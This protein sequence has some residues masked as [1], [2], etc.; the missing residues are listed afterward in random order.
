MQ[1]LCFPAVS[2]PRDAPLLA[3]PLLWK[4]A[5]RP[6]PSTLQCWESTVSLEKSRDAAALGQECVVE[7]FVHSLSMLLS[8]DS[9][10]GTGAQREK[11]DTVPALKEL[12]VVVGT[13]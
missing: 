10:L 1:S 11:E 6:P 3:E 7:K 5:P 8:T 13:L 9:G 4:E 12:R 2:R